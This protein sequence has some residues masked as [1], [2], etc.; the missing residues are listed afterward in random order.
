MGS[1]RRGRHRA[2]GPVAAESRGIRGQQPTD[3]GAHC[4]EHLGRPRPLR[5]QGCHATQRR[6]L[7]RE[8]CELLTTLGIR[9]CRRHKLGEPRQTPLRVDR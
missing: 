6:L 1:I 8:F 4:L 9:D 5:Y 2:V 7:L 3:L